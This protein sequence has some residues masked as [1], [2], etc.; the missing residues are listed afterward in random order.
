VDVDPITFVGTACSDGRG[1]TINAFTGSIKGTN[2]GTDATAVDFDICVSPD[3]RKVDDT[4]A[5]PS[6]AKRL[7]PERLTSRG[8]QN[9]KERRPPVR[10]SLSH[11]FG[12]ADGRGILVAVISPVRSAH[13]ERNCS[14]WTL[15]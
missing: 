3:G 11:H 10:S 15:V 5:L 8:G 7:P 2:N 9:F 13:S 1:G 14:F 6:S 4:E 12:G